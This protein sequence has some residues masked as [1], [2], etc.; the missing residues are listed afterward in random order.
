MAAIDTTQ[1]GRFTSRYAYALIAAALITVSVWAPL[2]TWQTAQFVGSGLI[3]VTPLVIP[4][5]LLAAWITASG[6]GDHVA[7]IFQ[8][9]PLQT[10]L[11]ATVVGAFL[12]VCGVTVLPLMAGLLAAGV[13]LAPVMAFWLASPI[14]GPAMLSATVA[15]LGWEYALGK[16]AAALGLGLLG[17]FGSRLFVGKEWSDSPLRSNSLVG[18]LSG[19]CS[20]NSQGY[21]PQI[22]AS[23]ERRK[24]FVR[25]SS[26]IARLIVLVLVPAFAAE[27]WLNALLSPHVVASYVGQD[28]A[29]AVV[30]AVLLGG[31]AY[32]DGYAA[33]PLTRAL[34]DNG[35]SSGAAMA[36]LVSGGVMSIW[37]AMA[38]FPVLRLQAFILYIAL[39]IT[40]SILAGWLFGIVN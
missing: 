4:G 13:P 26:S 18:V 40:G 27:F 28:S 30:I 35:M 33:L 39:A 24:R 16:S 15:T 7:S 2:E 8:G 5:V 25:D 22:W 38:I 31:P 21:N 1:R 20:F 29:W 9:K 36:F 6:A 37:G 32:I 23:S 14:T 34:L 10:I 12:P 11:S 19:G 17:G 3:Q